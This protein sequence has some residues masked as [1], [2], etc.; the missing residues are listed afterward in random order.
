MAPDG[1]FLLF[2][3]AEEARFVPPW[4][5][6]GVPRTDREGIGK[7]DRQLICIGKLS[8]LDSLAKWARPWPSGTSQQFRTW[9]P[10]RKVRIC[11]EMVCWSLVETRA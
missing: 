10:P 6:R 5:D 3:Q 2:A 9:A 4:D 8:A 7:C 11:N 1:E